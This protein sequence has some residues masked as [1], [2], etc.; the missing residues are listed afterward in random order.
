MSMVTHPPTL[1]SC[2]ARVLSRQ[3][4][5]RCSGDSAHVYPRSARYPQD[6]YG[7]FTGGASGQA[8]TLSDDVRSEP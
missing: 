3:R 2:H 4:Q 8:L 5:P 1:P 7:S 6:D